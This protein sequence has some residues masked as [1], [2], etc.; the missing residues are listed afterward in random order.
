MTDLA[1]AAL[2][3][4]KA[5]IAIIPCLPASKEPALRRTGKGHA[6]AA[7][8]DTD[9]VTK[10]WSVDP[11]RNIGI[12]CS[13]N[14]LTVIDIDGQPGNDF[15]THHGLPLPPPGP[16]PPPEASTTTTAGPQAT[17]IRTA[18]IAPKLE[19]RGDG[20]YV[21]APPSIH[22]DG[23]TY[24]WTQGGHNSSLTTPRLPA[25]WAALTPRPH[26][27]DN[28]TNNV[29]PLPATTQPGP[30]A[31]AALE[32][33]LARMAAATEGNRHN[34]LIAEALNIAGLIK[35]GELPKNAL[36]QLHETATR[37]HWPDRA[38]TEI[39]H[40][41]QSS[42]CHTAGSGR[43]ALPRPLVG[44]RSDPTTSTN[45]EATRTLRTLTAART[46]SPVW[47]VHHKNGHDFRPIPAVRGVLWR[48]AP[49]TTIAPVVEF[50]P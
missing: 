14:Q 43:D 6:A 50:P 30:W 41:V 8:T 11:D 39:E 19:I 7:S 44:T 12:V 42:G 9:T 47:S 20:A 17:K 36:N 21:I 27:T 46:S 38:P 40:A 48:L 45:P 33:A 1:I 34:T 29:V 32:N 22:P 35:G 3:Y 2:A 18:A 49:R 15:I 16:R 26:P 10:W 4:A 13:A 24:T 28:N 23:P 31:Q 5:G 25:Q 37:I